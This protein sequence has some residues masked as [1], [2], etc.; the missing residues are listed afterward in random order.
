MSELVSREEI[1]FRGDVQGVG[2]RMRTQRVAIARGLAG[3]V[4][5][6]PD[7]SVAC[8]VEGTQ[9][10]RDAFLV[11][12]EEVMSEHIDEMDRS[13]VSSD[14]PLRGF[15]IKLTSSSRR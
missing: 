10:D 14:E 11:A 9:T 12:L 15:S 13:P 6:E 2:F 5:N 8:L 3:W 7:G 4:C 1:V